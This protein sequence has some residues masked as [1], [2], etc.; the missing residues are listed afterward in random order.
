MSHIFIAEKYKINKPAGSYER[1]TCALSSA[2]FPVT[3]VA[4]AVFKVNQCRSA[5]SLTICIE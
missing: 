1:V 3:I 4:P 2:T 5:G